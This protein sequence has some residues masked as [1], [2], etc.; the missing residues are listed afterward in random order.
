M[1][2]PVG[3]GDGLPT[4]RPATRSGAT[5]EDWFDPQLGAAKSLHALYLYIR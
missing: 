4:G 1:P 3:L 5:V 2:P